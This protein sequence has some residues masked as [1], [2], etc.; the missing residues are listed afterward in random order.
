[1]TGHKKF[2]LMRYYYFF[3]FFYISNQILLMKTYPSKLGK[4]TNQARNEQKSKKLM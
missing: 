4:Q 1:M 3:F 2:H